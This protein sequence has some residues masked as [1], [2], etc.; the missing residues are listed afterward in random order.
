MAVE[1]M[2]LLSAAAVIL[3]IAFI[4][5][6][7]FRAN[8]DLA[9][10]QEEGEHFVDE[11]AEREEKLEEK[12]RLR[13]AREEELR[14][15]EEARQEQAAFEADYRGR[16]KKEGDGRQ[17]QPGP[18]R[19]QRADPGN[20]KQPRRFPDQK[21]S[22]PALL[23]LELD[24]NKRILRRIPVD[25]IPFRIGRSNDNDLVLD[26]LCVSRKHVTIERS[27]DRYV[28]VDLGTKNKIFSGGKLHDQLPLEAGVRFFIGNIEMLVEM[29]R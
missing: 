18:V 10:A 11:W 19:D 8:N 13:K 7:L 26:D 6:I 16:G 24:E 4:I 15:M 28:A 9:R 2:T 3:L 20:Q 29:K 21:E 17:K 12:R 14:K 1:W 5:F 23:L 25:H 27:G 22:R